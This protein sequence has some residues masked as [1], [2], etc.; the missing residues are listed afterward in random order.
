MVTIELF[1]WYTYSTNIFLEYNHTTMCWIVWVFS[2]S[3]HNAERA[4]K[5]LQK[6]I[7]RGSSNFEIR[8]LWTNIIWAN[9]LPIQWRETGFQP[10]SNETKTIWA[11]QNGE[12]F[13][14]KELR[15]S[16]EAKGHT[17]QTDC[18]TE[19]RVHLFEEYW[20][21]A[22]RYIDSEMFAS[23][24]FDEKNLSLYV[25]RDTLG[26]KPLYYAYHTDGTIH[27]V[28]ELKQLAQFEDINEIFDFPKGHY[29][30]NGQFFKYAN[31]IQKDLNTNQT[32]EKSVVNTLS[33]L[34]FD[35]VKKRVDTD[36]PIGV[37]LSWWVDS[38][39]IMEIANRIHPDVTAI[40]LGRPW[41]SDYEY[42][43]RLCKDRKYK[44]YSVIPDDNYYEH[45]EE[46]IYYCETYEPLIIRH[47]FAN[48]MCSKAAKQLGLKIVLVGEGADELFAGYNEFSGLSDN[49]IIE[50]CEK[51]TYNLSEWH[52]KRVDR[53]SMKY[54]VEARSPL[55]DTKLVNYAL[56]LPS[57]RKIKKENHQITVK[58]ILR[59]VAEQFLPDYIARRY[60]M[61]FAN[62]A[63]INVGNNF[64]SSDG[65]IAK[66]VD[67]LGN[68]SSSIDDITKGIFWLESNY[69]AF[70]Y[71]VF[72]KNN[73]NKLHNANQRIIVKDVLS[74]LEK[75]EKLKLL[76]AEFDNIP[77][78]FPVY[79]AAKKWF[80]DIHGLDVDFISTKG[81]YET[82]FA[83]NNNSAQIWLS[84][85]LFSMMDH[86]NGISCNLLWQ[87]ISGIPLVAVSI[88]PSI[89]IHEIA[90]MQEYIIW[91]YKKYTTAHTLSQYIL[92]KDILTFEKTDLIKALVNRDI[93]IWIMLYEDAIDLCKQGGKIIYQIQQNDLRKFCFTGFTATNT[94]LKK[95]ATAINWFLVA[96][97]EAIRALKKNKQ[98]ALKE[99]TALFPEI[100]ESEDLFDIYMHYR[101]DD[102][103]KEQYDTANAY[104]VRKTVY[105]DM[106]KKFQGQFF[107]RDNVDD[108]INHI[109]NKNYKRDHPFLEEKLIE[110]IQKA[111]TEKKKIPF[112][113]FWWVSNKKT[114]DKQ[115]LDTLDYLQSFFEKIKENHI[116]G[117]KI[118]IILADE[119]G[120]NNWFTAK[121]TDQ[122]LSSLAEEFNQREIEYIYL[123][124]LYKKS[125]FKREIAVRE[126]LSKQPL[127]RR[128]WLSIRKDLEEMSKKHYKK[129]NYIEWAQVYFALRILE[130]SLLE[131]YF[132][133]YIFIT[134]STSDY[135]IILPYLPTIYIYTTKKWNSDLPWFTTI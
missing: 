61:P 32:D 49:A 71:M 52:L 114:I 20:T 92:W 4:E 121:E 7:H 73:F 94:I 2:S 68:F 51:L 21:D 83:L 29:Y 18:D 88:N 14:Y 128:E 42:A 64:K 28:S 133:E 30:Y 119:H 135:Q 27:F 39:L 17:F 102:A 108:I 8:Q 116:P 59:K 134:Y 111:V 72:A 112:T 12:I 101:K 1:S 38:S 95:E 13:N 5:S 99:F 70:H 106:M 131:S 93:D 45:I 132:K 115:D 56:S 69:D 55:L 11:C 31:E 44:Y 81:D 126:Y 90:D 66:Y 3:L 129:W 127:N 41:S 6:I 23:I 107:E 65:E 123:S 9:R 76:V 130:K 62:G 33:Q 50:W 97:K 10:I 104:K 22:V 53:L 85:P 78:Y 26:V 122:Y 35:A 37:F 110:N 117:C 63:G 98:D 79:Y 124:E 19:I 105:P 54:T 16:L 96:I 47:A 87:L 43:L 80:F 24:T 74:T 48:D 82:Y 125:W 15:A 109:K 46:M 84:D 118:T 34:I 67:S 91:S 100:Q 120:R 89:H 60:K 86:N 36:L 25:C 77:L 40:I 75:S 103:D 58:Y 57:K 113:M